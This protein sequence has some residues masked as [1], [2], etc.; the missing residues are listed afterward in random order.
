[1]ARRLRLFGLA[2]LVVVDRQDEI[3]TLL[4][5]PAL[6][7]RFER[8]GPVINRL[9]VGALRRQ[10][11]RE[12]QM[13]LS[14]RPRE[15][16]ARAAGQRELFQRLDRFANA[17]G[18]APEAI[19]AMAH[20]VATGEQLDH[21]T[22]GLAYATAMPFLDPSIRGIFDAARYHEVFQLTR[23]LARTNAPADPRGWLIRLTGGARRARRAL[24]ELTGGDDYGLHALMVAIENNLVILENLKERVRESRATGGRPAPKLAWLSARTAPTVVLR[25]LHQ[26]FTLPHVADRLPAHTLVLMRMRRGL[27]PDTQGGFEFASNHWS[28]CPA[29][30]Y[31][32]ALFDAVCAAALPL[33]ATETRP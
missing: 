19:Y 27:R 23:R 20:Y 1:M 8:A 24:L 29:R 22:S 18:W 4:G 25:Q 15:D 31:V 16:E 11:L 6:E 30:R 7:R 3:D 28:A 32:I 12:G 13:L 21:A 10:F 33:L 5:H 9:L 17:K 14:M 2:S 26:D